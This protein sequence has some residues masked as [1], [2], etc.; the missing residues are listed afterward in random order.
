MESLHGT[1]NHA[2]RALLDGQ[3]TTPAKVAFAWRMAAGASL[4]RA[5]EPEW[6]DGVLV[7]R[8]RTDAWR[9]ELRH[10]RPVLTTRIQEL[11]GSDVVKKIVIE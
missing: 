3:P 11:V 8:A 9:R 2:L 7:V 4:S 5:G 1:A 6:R 10:A